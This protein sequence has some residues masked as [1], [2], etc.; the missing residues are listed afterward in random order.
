LTKQAINGVKGAPGAIGPY[1]QAI[2]VGDFL[3]CSGQIGLDPNTGNLAGDDVKIQA[4]RAMENIKAVLESQGLAFENVV[5]S[6]IF[7]TSMADFPLVNEVYGAYFPKEPPARSCVAVAALPKG[8][9]VEI[10]VIAAF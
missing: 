10:E 1:S 9:K 4:Q 3:F 6:T 7:L 8:A 2:R 5:K